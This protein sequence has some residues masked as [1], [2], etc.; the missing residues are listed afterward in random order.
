MRKPVIEIEWPKIEI[1]VEA[2][3][4]DYNKK[5]AE[6][7]FESLPFKTIQLHAMVTGELIYSYCPLNPIENMHLA[8]KRLR[9]HKLPPGYISWGGLGLVGIKYGPCTEPLRT[10]P[11]AQIPERFHVD[12]KRAGRATWEA[13]FNTKEKLIVEFR[14]KGG[15]R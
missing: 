1:I 9:I 5:Y 4:L 3:A 15:G 13:M 10:Q 2:V 8:E 7:F 11:I 14:K 12:L 6:Q